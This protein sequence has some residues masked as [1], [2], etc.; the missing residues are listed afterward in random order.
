MKNAEGSDSPLE[1]ERRLKAGVDQLRKMTDSLEGLIQVADAVGPMLGVARKRGRGRPA[2]R[3]A[4][5]AIS[6]ATASR[7]SSGSIPTAVSRCG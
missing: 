6:M 7:T 3:P 1:L 5:R 2:S 4:A